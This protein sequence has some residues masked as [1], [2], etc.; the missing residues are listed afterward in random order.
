MLYKY[1]IF[2]TVKQHNMIKVGYNNSQKHTGFVSHC[3]KPERIHFCVEELK[4]LHNKELFVINTVS[5]ATSLELLLHTHSNDYI[6]SLINFVPPKLYCRACKNVTNNKKLSFDDFVVCHPKCLNCKES[7]TVDNIFC[8]LD[9]DT[10][11]TSKTFDIVLEGVG[12]L[13]TLL[14]NI[15][16]KLCKYGFALIRPPGHHCSNK[17]SGFCVVNNVVV[18]SKYAQQIGYSKV[19]IFDIDFHHGDG[20]ENLIKNMENIS[21]CS[22]HGYGEGIY[23]GT[24]RA[25]SKTNILN[26]PLKVTRDPTSR[27]YITDDY[28]LNIVE[29]DV[30]SFI[31]NINPDIII[32]SCGFDGHCDDPLEGFNLTDNAYVRTVNCLKQFDTPLL[33]VT[34]GGYSVSAISRTIGKMVGAMI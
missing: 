12:V 34:E 4:K 3:E 6:Q 32:I 28:Y 30:V 26:I 18:A 22:I 23:P 19:F 24:G 9:P 7:T 31:T 29:S 25:C 15:K 10:Y 5:A 13:K 17:G 11:F 14:D 1:I 16:M 33:F 2:T 21:M 27:Q 20:T 8:Y